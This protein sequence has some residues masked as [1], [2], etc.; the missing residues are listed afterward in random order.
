MH[1]TRRRTL[2]TFEQLESRQLMAAD[3]LGSY[4]IEKVAVPERDCA[5]ELSAPAAELGAPTALR[6]PSANHPDDEQR[7]PDAGQGS[8]SSG[9]ADDSPGGPVTSVDPSPTS[10]L[11]APGRVSANQPA[12][13]S[14]LRMLESLPATLVD[15]A[16]GR[17]DI[18]SRD[19]GQ[20]AFT[21]DRFRYFVGS[22]RPADRHQ[23][24]DQSEVKLEDIQRDSFVAMTLLIDHPA[25]AP[26]PAEIR[27]REFDIIALPCGGARANH[28]PS[29]IELADGNRE[30]GGYAWS[31]SVTS[32]PNIPENWPRATRLTATAEG[33]N[34]FQV[35][36]AESVIA[37]STENDELSPNAE[38]PS[39]AEPRTPDG[40]T[41]A[42]TP[43]RLNLSPLQTIATLVLAAVVSVRHADRFPASATTAPRS[44]TFDKRL[45]AW[46]AGVRQLLSRFT[47]GNRENPFR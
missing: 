38:M 7:D 13:D 18:P 42:S 8:G 2:R 20:T 27:Q 1:R 10:P 29:P 40:V 12:L 4:L 9:P 43:W 47:Q 45:K 32:E 15:D 44:A 17:W 21:P 30:S 41:L 35:T 16:H 19:Y 31:Q 14:S 5:D 24:T 39:I 23:V 3:L 36:P 28:H 37:G 34:L 26:V 46:L 22:Y 11:I 6:Q 25:E 33:Q